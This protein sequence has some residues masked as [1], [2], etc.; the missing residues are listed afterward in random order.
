M[1]ANVGSSPP[2]A[3]A[4]AMAASLPDTESK[5]VKRSWIEYAVPGSNPTREP[6][7]AASAGVTTYVAALSRRGMSVTA[8]NTLSTLA[9]G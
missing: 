3:D 5:A 2:A 4:S 1:A 6:S 8:V 7:T 9:G